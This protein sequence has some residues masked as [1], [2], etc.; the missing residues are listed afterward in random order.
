MVLRLLERKRYDEVV[1]PLKLN[2]FGKLVILITLLV[3]IL[4]K[5]QDLFDIMRNMFLLYTL[6]AVIVFDTSYTHKKD[7]R[8]NNREQE[9]TLGRDNT[10][11]VEASEVHCIPASR[12]Y[13]VCPHYPRE[14]QIMSLNQIISM[15]TQ[16]NIP[17]TYN[18][19]ENPPVSR[20][21]RID[22]HD[23]NSRVYMNNSTL[24]A[25]SRPFIPSSN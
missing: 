24:S 4:N 14:P 16:N 3:Y 18:L 10:V 15:I 20:A 22:L 8:L 17:T 13:P 7:W 6:K 23:N 2:L 19:G 9:E 25:N 11:P 21:R 5:N 1:F 12:V